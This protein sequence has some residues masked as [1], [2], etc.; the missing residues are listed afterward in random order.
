MPLG[1]HVL[2]NVGRLAVEM[3]AGGRDHTPGA[4][5]AK[6][7]QVT[8]NAFNPMG[9]S[10]SLAQ[11]VTPTVADSAVALAQNQDWTGRPIYRETPTL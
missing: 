4:K 11:L 5:L 2:P 9:G 10:Q 6:L 7:L 1:F 3:M 8:L